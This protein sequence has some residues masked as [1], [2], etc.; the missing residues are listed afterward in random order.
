MRTTWGKQHCR[1]TPTDGGETIL[2]VDRPLWNLDNASIIYA[3][4]LKKI[5]IIASTH[6]RALKDLF[7]E[8]NLLLSP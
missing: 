1:M 4:K 6:P 8:K 2:A 5:A 3:E 7:A